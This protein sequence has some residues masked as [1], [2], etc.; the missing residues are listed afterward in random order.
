MPSAPHPYRAH[1]QRVSRVSWPWAVL[2]VLALVA[3]AFA[4]LLGWAVDILACD[5]GGSEACERKGL[6]R[7][8]FFVALACAGLLWGFVATV[9]GRR[10]QLARALLGFAVPLYLVWALLNDAAV[11]GW[12]SDMTFV[13]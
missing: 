10:F 7:A 13:P 4:I 12:G 5:S 2:A 3:G 8:Q 9:I 1:G 6:A 11:H